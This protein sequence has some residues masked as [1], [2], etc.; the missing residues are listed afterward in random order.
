M[1]FLRAQRLLIQAIEDMSFQTK[2]S[3]KVT[4]MLPTG[5]FVKANK[6]LGLTAAWNIPVLSEFPRGGSEEAEGG[7]D[8][9]HRAPGSEPSVGQRGERKEQELRL[10]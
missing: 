9:Q 8:R 2:K 3:Q 4:K 1:F 10:R 5:R 7:E 6:S